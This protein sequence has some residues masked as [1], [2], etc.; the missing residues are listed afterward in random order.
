MLN[1]LLSFF[2][3]IKSGVF[4]T[5]SSLLTTIVNIAAGF[6]VLRW[7]GPEEMGVW[8]ALLIINTYAVIGNLGVTTGL[9]REFPFLLGKGE[10]DHAL[11]L[12][13]T[14]KAYTFFCALISFI[15]LGIALAY[16]L[17]INPKGLTFILSFIAVILIL[18]I[19][20]YKDYLITLFRT[21]KAFDKLSIT[22]LIQAV[23]SIALLF[24]IY[25]FHYYGFIL[26]NVLITIISLVLLL[27][28]TPFKVDLKFNF[29][30]FILLVKTGLPLFIMSY[31]FGV[32][33][34]FIKFAIL[35]F[36]GIQMLGLF[37][38][39]FAIRNGI[40][41]LPK[42]ISQYLYP[43]FSFK[44]GATGDSTLLWR[45]VR[46]ISFLLLTCLFFAILPIYYFMPELIET[47]F[48]KYTESIFASRL[49]LVSGVFFGSFIGV[50]VLNSVKGY[51][52]RLIITISY[53]A[54]SIVLP[55]ALPFFFSNK[56][57]ALAWAILIIDVLY[58][59]VAYAVTRKKLL[60]N[61]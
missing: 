32:S 4:Y 50:F 55:F 45:P 57:I 20:F 25:K 15:V 46:N 33:K 18:T 47:F 34:S 60:S 11:V 26:Y 22:Y 35:Y 21:N 23:I 29:K 13:S 24:L 61:A 42:I 59:M 54:F 30:D 39:V 48:P 12:A 31:L 8:Q 10:K 2:K 36:G 16:F 51:K 44:L 56:I 1:Q 6:L 49:A 9:A 40:N 7:V 38:P 19:N 14:A 52:E 58:F 27:L 5:A 17:F 43:R 53:I 37:A 28:I 3:K 41:T